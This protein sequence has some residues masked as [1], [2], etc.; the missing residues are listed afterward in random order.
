MST[1][2]QIQNKERRRRRAET[3]VERVEIDFLILA[4]WAETINGKLYIQGGGWD[5]KLP[6]P[7][8][9]PVDI[10]I[11]AGILVPWH[12]TNRVHQ[13]SLAFETGD[14]IAVVP[15]MTGGFNMGRPA[16]A[17]PGQKLRIPFA[18]RIGIK[19]PGLGPYQVTLTVNN[20]VSKQVA[21]YVVGEL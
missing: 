8:G 6:A 19:L 3:P 9:Q 17:L 1:G 12:L 11:A 2:E 13:F 18:A 16:K 20:E 4:D 5:R 15:P 21:F 7:D 14:G 10:F